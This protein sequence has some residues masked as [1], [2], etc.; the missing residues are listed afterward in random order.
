MEQ[1]HKLA[2]L[3]Q[4]IAA[5]DLPEVVEFLNE[6]KATKLGRALELRLLRQ[7][8]GNDPQAAA[9][10]VSRIPTEGSA[11]PH[12]INAVASV[13]ANQDLAGA[14]AW[15]NQ[16]PEDDRPGGLLSVAYEAARTEPTAA[17]N[18]AAGLPAGQS[19]EDLVVHAARQWASQDPK[20]AA[21]WAG[22]ITEEGLR[23]RVLGA[24]ATE[25]GERDPAAAATLA[26]KSMAPGK[27]Q[28]DAVV[29]IVQRWVQKEPA[30]AAAWVTA[31][32]EGPLQDAAMK[33][34]LHLWADQNWQQPG[35]WLA[36]LEAGPGR[37]TGIGAYVSKLTPSFPETAAWWTG[38][39][40]NEAQRSLQM[41][42]LA[43]AWI[44]SDAPAARAWIS[45]APMPDAVKARW[46]AAASP[47][48]R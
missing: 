14:T 11:R 28:D 35:A 45:Q 1:A 36:T 30:E 42:A 37:D 10:W 31:F 16:L 19:Q 6:E 2:N 48:S 13:W 38:L 27:P 26:I 39:I 47:Q 40:G 18:L 21:D 44:G 23:D 9:N 32:P 8:A 15:V 22:Q 3:A 5:A 24:V 17:L 4:E 46:L 12:A 25:W 41:E 29:G 20:G 33:N 34:L 7:W 43:E